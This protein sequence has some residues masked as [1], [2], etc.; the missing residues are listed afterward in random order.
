MLVL[1]Q[2]GTI[3]SYDAWE[4]RVS[5]AVLCIVKIQDANPINYEVKSRYNRVNLQDHE[6]LVPE[7]AVAF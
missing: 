5:R 7:L 4:N 2:L 3:V 6:I 1:G